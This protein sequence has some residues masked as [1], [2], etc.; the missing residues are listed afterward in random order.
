M[1]R[2]IEGGVLPGYASVAM[3]NKALEQLTVFKGAS[4]AAK[5]RLINN[6]VRECYHR[7]D[8]LFRQGKPAEYLWFVLEGWVHLV[9]E[10]TAAD[11]AHA[12]ALFTVTP[13]EMLCGVS[14]LSPPS[15]YTATAIAGGDVAALRVPAA[16]MQQI[17]QQ[18]PAVCYEVLKLCAQRLRHMSE[19]CSVMAQDVPSRITQVLLRLYEQFGETIPITHRELAQLAWTTTESAIRCVR[20]LKQRGLVE[21]QRGEL[22]LRQP[23]ALRRLLVRNESHGEVSNG[24]NGH[25]AHSESRA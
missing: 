16:L 1:I 17:L 4:H 23:Q 13:Q 8:V 24:Y 11:A 21:G 9:R 19:H 3:P 20:Q 14:V 2:V 22:T 12:I 5:N 6:A 18:E 10:D 25:R 15:T 7:G